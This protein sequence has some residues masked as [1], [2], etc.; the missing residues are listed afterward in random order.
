MTFTSLCAPVPSCQSPTLSS[1]QDTWMYRIAIFGCLFWSRVVQELTG[2]NHPFPHILRRFLQAIHW[3]IGHPWQPKGNKMFLVYVRGVSIELH[4]ITLTKATRTTLSFTWWWPNIDFREV[5][6][7]VYINVCKSGLNRP[8][9][10]KAA[11][12]ERQEVSGM[13]ITH[14][15]VASRALPVLALLDRWPNDC[16]KSTQLESIYVIHRS[17]NSA[18]K[19]FNS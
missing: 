19:T 6:V 9:L 2:G 4:A 7:P 10:E 12:W 14:W 17:C 3:Y 13:L 16:C 11:C 18:L 15:N 8:W 5:Q 1:Q